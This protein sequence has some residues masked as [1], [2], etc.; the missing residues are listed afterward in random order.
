MHAHTRRSKRLR[1]RTARAPLLCTVIGA[2]GL[3]FMPETLRRNSH[4]FSSLKFSYEGVKQNAVVQLK[5]YP[6]FACTLCTQHNAIHIALNHQP[7]S[8][9]YISSTR[10]ARRRTRAILPLLTH[11]KSIFSMAVFRLNCC[12]YMHLSC[13]DDKPIPLL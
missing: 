7:L 9:R 11:I 13:R 8:V 1:L 12:F 6:N 4:A 3:V 10:R 2:S 5:T